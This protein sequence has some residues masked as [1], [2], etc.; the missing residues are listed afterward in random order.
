MGNLEYLQ[1][2]I[3]LNKKGYKFEETKETITLYRNGNKVVIYNKESH[4]WGFI[5]ESYVIPETARFDGGGY[6]FTVP[7]N[8]IYVDVETFDTLK[9]FF[10]KLRPTEVYVNVGGK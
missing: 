10:E 7:N 3:E 1:S 2:V 6:T 8:E 4:E 5:Y 9:D